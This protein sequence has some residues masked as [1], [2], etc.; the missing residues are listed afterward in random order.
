MIKCP[1]VE[2]TISSAHRSSLSTTFRVEWRATFFLPPSLPTP[3]MLYSRELEQQHDLYRS[4]TSLP[5]PQ[6]PNKMAN[7]CPMRT[8][9]VFMLENSLLDTHEKLTG[10]GM[11]CH[12]HARE[13]EREKNP[14]VRPLKKSQLFFLLFQSHNWM[15]FSCLH[16]RRAIRES[17]LCASLI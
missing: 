4:S 2:K 8:T 7:I 12:P 17:N 14:K 15:G 9:R 10:K 6:S 16:S 13:R 3:R 1:R 5:T 11:S